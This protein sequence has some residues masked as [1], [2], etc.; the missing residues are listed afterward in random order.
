MSLSGIPWKSKKWY[1]T[2]ENQGMN[3]RQRDVL[4]WDIWKSTKWYRTK[5]N[6]GMNNRQR[7]VLIWDIW[8]SKKWYRTKENQGMNNRQRDVLIWDIWKSTKWY[9][10]KENQGMNNRQRDVLIWDIWK[11]TKWYRTKENQGMNNRQ[12]D[13]L[14]WD[15]WKST[16]WYRT[17][18]NQEMN[19]RQR[20]VLIWDIWKSKKWYRTKKNQGMNNRQRD[21]LIW[22]TW[23]S[24][25][26]YRT[27]ENQG[28]NNRQRD[29]LIWDTWKSTKWYRTKENQGMN[30]RQ[31]DV[32]IWDIWKS[33]KWYR[34]KENQGMITDKEMSLSGIY[35]RVRN[36]GKEQAHFVHFNLGLTEDMPRIS[37]LFYLSG[38]LCF[39]PSLLYRYYV[40]VTENR[41][42][43][44]AQ[45]YCQSHYTDLVAIG[46]QKQMDLIN[47]LIQKTNTPGVWI[48]LYRNAST[49]LWQWSNGDQFM[50]SRWLDR[51]P[52]QHRDMCTAMS[53]NWSDAFCSNAYYFV[54]FQVS[55]NSY[56]LVTKAVT[57]TVARDYC[58]GQHTELVSIKND[59]ENQEVKSI[60]GGYTVWIGLYWDSSSG[61][62]QWADGTFSSYQNWGGN[63]PDN[64]G[65][66]EHCT[67]ICVNW[68]NLPSGFWN[69]YICRGTLYFMCYQEV[70]YYLIKEKMTFME[71]LFYCREHFTDIVSM[72]HIDAQMQ[73]ADF[74]SNA[75]GDGVWIGLHKD[76]ISGQWVWMNKDPFYYFNWDVTLTDAPDRCMVMK[77]DNFNWTDSCCSNSYEFI[78]Y[79][80]SSSY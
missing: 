65:G 18:E 16:K 4:I 25:K 13:V 61:Q 21:V 75:S 20:Y 49:Y 51:Q 26:W 34:T 17:K 53:S 54:C 9:R 15:I 80:K 69:D 78:C 67:H 70:E 19:N 46:S 77:T 7:D 66:L 73:V 68:V 71:A 79:N 39:C 27:K 32:L 36:A 33:T 11:S 62:W 3:N 74:A 56:Y 47:D 31:R 37:A 76:Q 8:K 72:P 14:I 41:D 24:T 58:R 60:I 43:L 48:G 28:M 12:R 64:Y 59:A 22:D 40:L 44:Q 50:Y 10:T 1:R 52:G 23:K 57:W 5:E 2:K 45:E 6:Q 38:A 29:V 30:N 35:G 42:W 63:Q 55:S